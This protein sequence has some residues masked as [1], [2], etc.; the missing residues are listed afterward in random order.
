MFTP[1]VI[2]IIISIYIALCH[3]VI[4]ALL[5][6]NKS[7]NINE[8]KIQKFL[9][10]EINVFFEK[11]HFQSFSEILNMF[12]I[13]HPSLEIAFYNVAAAFLCSYFFNI[14]HMI[15]TKKIRTKKYWLQYWLLDLYELLGVFI[16]IS[17]QIH[18]RAH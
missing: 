16:P 2:I 7:Y 1:F 14:N 12:W 13:L 5:H 15:D 11:I 18:I 9:S 3:A 10:T 8:R 17:I 6:T 4:K